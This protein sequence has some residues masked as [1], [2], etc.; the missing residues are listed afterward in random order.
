MFPSLAAAMSL[1]LCP[2]LCDPI[3]GHPP[4]SSVPGTLQARRLE[5]L[6]FPSPLP[7][8]C[9][10]KTKISCGSL[11]CSRHFIA[12]VW[13]QTQKYL[14]DQPVKEKQTQRDEEASGSVSH[15]W[16]VNARGEMST[17]GVDPRTQ[18]YNQTQSTGPF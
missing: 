11:H 13:N 5:W 15:I 6:P 14:H 1:Q 9:S 2:T 10:R 4:G 18:V 12:V 16:Q 7:N 8:I 17:Q 3:D